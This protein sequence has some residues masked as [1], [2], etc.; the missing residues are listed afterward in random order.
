MIDEAEKQGQAIEVQAR[1]YEGLTVWINSL[2]A[3]AG[4]QIVDQDGNVKVGRPATKAAE[5]MQQAG[6][7]E[8]APPGH[9]HQQGGPGAPGLRVG[10][11]RLP[12]QLPFVY[13]SAGGHRGQGLPEE[14]RLGALSADGSRTSRAARRSAAS[15]S[16]SAP[17][18]RTRTWP[19]TPPS[20][21]RSPR[22]R[23]W[24]PRRAPAAHHR[25]GL[26]RPQG[27]EGLP[28]RRPA[29]RVDRAGSN[30]RSTRTYC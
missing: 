13:P 20:A 8:A 26:Q 29:A 27:Q 14:H 18:R 19:S 25:V 22:T 16:A 7:V 12:G 21:S 3:G 23:S 2:I 1:Q 6:H 28:V 10:P 9:G 15:T 11:L 24:P 4:G 5:I 30:T 17:T